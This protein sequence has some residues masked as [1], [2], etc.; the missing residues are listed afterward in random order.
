MTFDRL[1]AGQ[2]PS[3]LAWNAGQ[4]ADFLAQWSGGGIPIP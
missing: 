2:I 1:K 3:L 4:D